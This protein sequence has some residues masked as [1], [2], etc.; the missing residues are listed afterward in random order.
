MATKDFALPR[1]ANSK[2]S[3]DVTLEALADADMSAVF[4]LSKVNAGTLNQ[5]NLI[6]CKNED[7]TDHIFSASVNNDI[8]EVTLTATQLK[9][10]YE[11]AQDGDWDYVQ[12][13]WTFGSVD[14]GGASNMVEI[15]SGKTYN[16]NGWPPSE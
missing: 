8:G 14:A 16:L 9:T 15:Q 1:D 7:V 2:Q 6:S 10:V 4:Q 5:L 13:K 3:G 12:A 11:D